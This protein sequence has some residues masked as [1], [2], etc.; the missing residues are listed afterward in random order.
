MVQADYSTSIV[1]TLLVTIKKQPTFLGF[2]SC[3][4]VTYTYPRRRIDDGRHNGVRACRARA[5][6]SVV[7]DVGDAPLRSPSRTVTY[8]ARCLAPR[9]QPLPCGQRRRENPSARGF[10]RA[11]GLAVGKLRR[12]RHTDPCVCAYTIAYVVV[13]VVA[14]L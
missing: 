4:T 10:F 3:C 14:R 8:G 9:I 2:E 1:C 11:G 12:R 5:T 13:V 7:V 6:V